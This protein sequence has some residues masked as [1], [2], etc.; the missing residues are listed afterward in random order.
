MNNLSNKAKNSIERLLKDEHILKFEPAE[1]W[2]SFKINPKL[3]RRNQDFI[4]MCAESAFEFLRA[5]YIIDDF[6]D[7][8]ERSKWKYETSEKYGPAALQFLQENAL[9]GQNYMC[10]NSCLIYKEEDYVGNNSKR[11]NQLRAELSETY[12]MLVREERASTPI[13]LVKNLK[14]KTYAWLKFLSEQRVIGGRI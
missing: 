3:F 11:F 9:R 6:K 7:H 12:G 5:P 8:L 10:V 13:E 14:Q 2:Q 4:E 1:K